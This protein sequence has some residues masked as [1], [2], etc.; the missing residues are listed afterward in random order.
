M[1][2][3]GRAKQ[4]Q[5]PRNEILGQLFWALRGSLSRYFFS[6]FLAL[7]ADFWG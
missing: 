2:G 5:T 4:R 6:P 1:L 7:I 3:L